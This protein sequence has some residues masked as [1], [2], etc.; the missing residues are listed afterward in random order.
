[1][2]NVSDNLVGR[3]ILQFTRLALKHTIP[4]PQL[5]LLWTS[6]I[7]PRIPTLENELAS[8]SDSLMLDFLSFC[9]SELPLVFSFTDSTLLWSKL[10]TVIAHHSTKPKIINKLLD[11][12]EAVYD[13]KIFTFDSSILQ[14]LTFRLSLTSGL[15]QIRVI[16]AI[17]QCAC[18]AS[19]EDPQPAIDA[20]S[21]LLA[22]PSSKCSETVKA[23]I[24]NTLSV[25]C[26][27]INDS[28]YLQ[29]ASLL[30]TLSLRTARQAVVHFL[31][32][33]DFEFSSIVASLE[34][35]IRVKLE[36][37]PDYETRQRAI[38]E[39]PS[40]TLE[41]R[42]WSI[43][44]SVL[45]HQMTLEDLTLRAYA[46]NAIHSYL[47]GPTALTLVMS[48][49]YPAIKAVLKSSK[50]SESIRSEHVNLLQQ[51]ITRFDSPPFSHMKP[52]LSFGH[53]ED[54]ASFFYNIY[55]VQKHRRARAIRRLAEVVGENAS[56][57]SRAFLLDILIPM[58]MPFAIPRINQV[59]DGVL[60]QDALNTLGFLLSL[61]PPNAFIAKIHNLVARIGG[62]KPIEKAVI[63]LIPIAI[64]HFKA[65]GVLLEERLLPMLLSLWNVGKKNFDVL[66]SRI[67]IAVGIA[68]LLSQST[69]QR[70]RH[71]PALLT[72]LAQALKCR[73]RDEVR[74]M[75]RKALEQITVLLGP[76][77][78]PSTLRI[79][80]S[81]VDDGG[82]EAYNSGYQRHVMLHV[83]CTL[84]I[85]S[86]S[87]DWPTAKHVLTSILWGGALGHMA[88]EKANAE[89]T[90]KLKEVRAQRSYEAIEHIVTLIPLESLPE[91][92][93]DL[94]TFSQST[95]L[96]KVISALFNAIVARTDIRNMFSSTVESV[97]DITPFINV[98]NC[99]LSFTWSQVLGM[100]L[101]AF[102]LK[103]RII[104]DPTNNVIEHRRFLRTC[105]PDQVTRHHHPL[106]LPQS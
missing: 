94:D 44:L 48:I 99:C 106:P 56:P 105:L 47:D 17:R 38:R 4:I 54:E 80:L 21:S 51:L 20:L 11:I 14:A 46:S 32:T 102:G 76:T 1:M 59:L 75:S 77:S 2:R 96:D 16:S 81:V 6:L 87:L 25:L 103:N 72:T 69:I 23:D 74:E 15:L 37:E 42:Q 73:D 71:L 93:I 98:I 86:S 67:P 9:S 66:I 61:L 84:I 10:V 70:G 68:R 55:H 85:Q 3:G 78:L 83:I 40:L 82:K 33:V 58:L 18:V 88:N 92:I 91:L 8:A 90:G 31:S 35:W 43:I 100:R 36:D 60:Q 12:I 39:L 79:L 97:H 62:D 24:L 7:L 28:F 64:N 27:T 49:I 29:I 52:L 53:G 34:S 50:K 19:F 5:E 65:D 30:R 95:F 101:F 41:P 22:L 104:V 45:M 89:W 63:K 57:P 13:K 26:T